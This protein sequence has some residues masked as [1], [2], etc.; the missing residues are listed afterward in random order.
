MRRNKMILDNQF[1]EI[2]ERGC[3][4]EDD[5]REDIKESKHG[6]LKLILYDSLPLSIGAVCGGIARATGC[7]EIIAVLPVMSFITGGLMPSHS[8]RAMGKSLMGWTGYAIGAS[9]PYADKIYQAI[10]DKF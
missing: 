6:R 4:M 8:P 3:D 5:F 9:L 1:K 10:A 7:P 2:E